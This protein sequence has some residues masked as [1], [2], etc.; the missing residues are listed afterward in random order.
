LRPGGHLVVSD[1]MGDEP[2]DPAPH[3]RFRSRS[4]WESG[5]SGSG[6][7]LS[8]VIPLYR[9]LSRDRTNGPIGR[10][11]DVARGP[12]EYSLERLGIGTPHMRCAVL[13]RLTPSP[14]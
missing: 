9:W 12:F 13:T 11:P 1:G 5:A 10:L 3:V 8:E 6:L 2:A 14:G 4:Q 7:E